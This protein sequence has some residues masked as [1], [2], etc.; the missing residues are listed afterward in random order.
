MNWLRENWWRLLLI[1]ILAAL[2]A[3]LWDFFPGVHLYGEPARASGVNQKYLE[4]SYADFNAQYFKER[5]PKDVIID[6]ELHD[7]EFMA[8]T[9]REGSG[10]FRITFNPYYLTAERNADLTMLHE[11]CHVKNWGDEHGNKW[12]SC[13]IQLDLAGAF[14]EQLIDSY[15]EKMK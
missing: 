10:R 6:Y 13:M 12:R 11:Q 1:V 3:L 7:S 5:L 14:R 8:L 4:K 9:Q 15:Q 2:W